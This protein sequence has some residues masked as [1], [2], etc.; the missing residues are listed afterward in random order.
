MIP[1]N[2]IANADDFGFDKNITEGSIRAYQQGYINSVSILTN[3]DYFE[4]AIPIIKSYPLLKNIGIHINFTLGKPLTAIDKKYLT[5]T[6]EWNRAVT[7]KIFAVP[8]KQSRGAFY[9]E[10]CYQIERA[11]NAGININ[12]LNSHH[13]VHILPCFA[14]LFIKATRNYGLKLRLAQTRASGSLLK[15]LYRQ[16]LN[17]TIISNNL[18]YTDYFEHPDKIING[19]GNFA[20]LKTL[21]LMFHPTLNEYGELTDHYDPIGFNKWKECFTNPLSV[22]NL[23]MGTPSPL[24][25]SWGIDI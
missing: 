24:I 5:A 1:S 23:S 3:S 14:G 20:G 12:H 19:I 4:E 2:I 7:G 10:I 13:H 9:K 6:G 25:Q 8:D 17:K 18:N 11:L 15:S 21:E 16:Q 22:N